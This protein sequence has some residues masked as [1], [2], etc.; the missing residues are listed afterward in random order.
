MAPGGRVSAASLVQ[1]RSPS[2]DHLDWPGVAHSV[3]CR[4]S[5]S[6]QDNVSMYVHLH[7]YQYKI[8]SKN[9]CHKRDFGLPPGALQSWAQGTARLPRSGR[10]L[11]CPMLCLAPGFGPRQPGLR[12][13][14]LPAAALRSGPRSSPAL[15]AVLLQARPRPPST[16]RSRRSKRLQVRLEQHEATRSARRDSAISSSS[17]GSAP[18]LGQELQ[19]QVSWTGSCGDEGQAGAQ[20]R[21][22]LRLVSGRWEGPTCRGLAGRPF[23]AGVGAGRRRGAGSVWARGRG[24]GGLSPRLSPGKGRGWVQESHEGAWGR[25]PR[26]L[27]CSVGTG[28]RPRRHCAPAGWE[29]R[30]RPG[31]AGEAGLGRLQGRALPAALL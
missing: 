30:S 29:A 14:S 2:Q 15:S 20:G 31:V 7:R 5:G 22:L 13:R 12:P 23:L 9:C 11:S 3:A 19:P 6:V 28:S 4:W 10:G 21:S 26:V 16:M 18:L 27:L 8:V 25:G 1:S 17:R 24:A